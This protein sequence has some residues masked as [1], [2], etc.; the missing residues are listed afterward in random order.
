[1]FLEFDE[2]DSLNW[3]NNNSASS[4]SGY[5]SF[6]SLFNYPSNINS[7]PTLFSLVFLHY[8]FKQHLN[9]ANVF[10]PLSL[11]SFNS[12]HAPIVDFPYTDTEFEELLLNFTYGASSS[13]PL[14]PNISTDSS[15]FSKEFAAFHELSL[16]V[17]SSLSSHYY[18]LC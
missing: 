5:V 17:F 13:P 12:S 6:N 4:L 3:K 16:H 18:F 1:M 11:L 14:T 7:F 9:S 2:N 10:P 8:R 15:I